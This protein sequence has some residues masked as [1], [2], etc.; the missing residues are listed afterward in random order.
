MQRLFRS[1]S[2]TTPPE[3]PKP[4]DKSNQGSGSKSVDLTTAVEKLRGF[5]DLAEV[6]VRSHSNCRLH[7]VHAS[8]ESDLWC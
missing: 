7:D 8:T 4:A 6:S 3:R 2:A 5:R 1:L